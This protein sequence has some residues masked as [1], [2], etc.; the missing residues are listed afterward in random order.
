M[1]YAYS[2]EDEREIRDS[3]S[4][5][6][7][8]ISVYRDGPV[9]VLKIEPSDSFV[10][11]F[12]KAM[13]EMSS[14]GYNIYN[15]GDQEIIV[16]R[17]N[18]DGNMKY[19]KLVLLL[20]TLITIF[21]AG[22]TYSYSYYRGQVIGVVLAKTIL[23]FVLPVTG[24]LASREIPKY[25]IRRKNGQKYSL[26]IFVPNPIMMGTLGVI[27]AP[28]EPYKS[29]DQQLFSGFSSLI[30][31][32]IVSMVF[33]S[34]GY[35][36]FSL[37]HGLNYGPNSSINLVNLP[38]FFQV[39]LG[40]FLPAQGALDPLALSG[41]AGLI[42][43]SFNAFPVGFLDGASIF[44]AL[45]PSQR[46]N[47]SYVFLTIL[48]FIDL[49]YPVW[50]ILPLFILLI[51]LDVQEPMNTKLRRVNSRTLIIIIITLMMA[52]VGLT[53]FPV[54]ISSPS[55]EVSTSWNSAV[56]VNNSSDQACFQISVRNLGQIAVD[57]GFYISNGIPYDVRAITGDIDPGASQTYCMTINGTGLG[58]GMNTIDAKVYVNSMSREVQLRILKISISSNITIIQ[59]PH[60]N[61]N[62]VNLTV[63]ST[64]N[65]NL[66]ESMFIS[67]PGDLNYSMTYSIGR[68]TSIPVPMNGTGAQKFLIV[69]EAGLS[70]WSMNVDLS[71]A[72]P[73]NIPVQ[74]AV[75]DSSYKGACV[76]IY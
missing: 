22:F 24:I 54:H 76:T 70:P 1:T 55:I 28:D 47:I 10:D 9:I 39:I 52:I 62:G 44:S 75:Y 40:R 31:G 25:L 33:L 32:L 18:M 42:F 51:G 26:P 65:R 19:L 71:M 2:N 7:K 56:I 6:F 59:T 69:K 30:C 13:E 36:G 4:S 14:K 12:Q 8:V 74:F 20:I 5:F 49:T 35:Y 48:V 68:N 37:Y 16:A 67:A 53:P 27:N 57:P 61:N 41:W 34:L 43:T 64:Y 17:R 29:S 46:K 38:I 72:I 58:I 63:I 3:I 45:S 66:S 11:K 60:G 21:Y 73:R 15:N 50:F 23:F